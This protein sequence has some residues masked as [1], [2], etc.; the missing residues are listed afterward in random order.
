MFL[1]WNNPHLPKN[2][3][4]W[5]FNK[6]CKRINADHRN[7][8]PREWDMIIDFI[9]PEEDRIL[10]K[11]DTQ[12]P[13]DEEEEVDVFNYTSQVVGTDVKEDHYISVPLSE[14]NNYM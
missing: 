6:L 14:K 10:A 1:D 2:S 5:K 11:M 13:I 3:E 12:L 8:S 7:P 4:R 9:Y